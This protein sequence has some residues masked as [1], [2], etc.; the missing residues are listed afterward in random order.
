MKYYRRKKFNIFREIF[1]KLPTAFF[2][3]LLKKKLKNC[4]TIL[5]I[6]CGGLSPLRF[7]D[8]ET[9]G[10]DV[11]GSAIKQ[12]KKNMTHSAFKTMD[13]KK[14]A[15]KFQPKSFEAVVSLDV[16]EHL[17]KKDGERLIAN[18]EKITRK[19]VIIFTPNGFMPQKGE[20]IYDKHLSGWTIDEMKR[21]GY[22]VFGIYGPRILRGE[23]HKI[24]FRPEFFWTIVSEL[25]QWS[26][27]YNNPRKATALL[28]I[29][30]IK[31]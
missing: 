15:E 20:L 12:A 8:G 6:G 2:Y 10:I 27:I 29:K 24:K 4:Q 25:I 30:D 13:I 1:P 28:C 22:Q 9:Y 26:F 3:L 21:K 17:K 19:K 5:D 18:M 23:R 14:I 16:I 31:N 7:V 11:Y